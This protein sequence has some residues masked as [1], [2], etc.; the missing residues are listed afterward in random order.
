MEGKKLSP[1]LSSF[2]K[3]YFSA[4]PEIVQK[5]STQKFVFYI[6]II[7]TLVVVSFFTVVVIRPTV[8]T[9]FDLKS[10]YTENEEVLNALDQKLAAITALKAQQA[11]LAEELTLLSDVI[12]TSHNIPGLVRKIEVIAREN[13]VSLSQIETGN[14]EVFPNDRTDSPFYTFNFNMSVRGDTRNLNSF[15][16]DLIQF[17]RLISIDRVSGGSVTGG[18][19]E[20]VIVGRSYFYDAQGQ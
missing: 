17:D 1:E 5:L 19:A 11:Q 8:S 6:Y 15:L 9:I 4:H 10:E 7:L 18:D 13:N 12:P 3:D 2:Y 14:I 16:S 20:Y